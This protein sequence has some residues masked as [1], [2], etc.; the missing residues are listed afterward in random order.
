M[1]TQ[2]KEECQRVAMAFNTNCDGSGSS[3]QSNK[4]IRSDRAEER[5][6]A[7]VSETTGD[8]GSFM[9]ISPLQRIAAAGSNSQVV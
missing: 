6:R 8:D 2:M 4:T 3:D 5:R 9:K 7:V 1:K